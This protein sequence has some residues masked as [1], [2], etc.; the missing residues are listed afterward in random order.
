MHVHLLYGGF[1]AFQKQFH[2]IAEKFP[3]T[4]P[5]FHIRFEKRPSLKPYLF[6]KRKG[7]QVY[8]TVQA[9]YLTSKLILLANKRRLSLLLSAEKLTERIFKKTDR[10]KNLTVIKTEDIK[11]LNRGN[12]LIQNSCVNQPFNA[13]IAELCLLGT[14]LYQCTFSS[15]LGKTLFV[16]LNG[17][18]SFCPERIEQTKIGYLDDETPVFEREGF[19]KVLEKQV[20]KR[21]DCKK[22]CPLFSSCKGGC[23]L[24]DTCTQFKTAHKTTVQTIDG[25]VKQNLPLPTDDKILSTALLRA[26]ARG[27]LIRKD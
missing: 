7:L 21:D 4:A 2:K 18:V 14:P 17:E 25:I 3:K 27:N 20:E 5:V 1:R 11:A 9:K 26:A 24:I 13:D 6:L 12:L 15:C 23:A 8:Y 22:T 16:D 10:L 19:L